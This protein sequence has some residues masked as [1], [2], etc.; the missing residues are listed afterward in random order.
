MK[1]SR[2]QLDAMLDVVIDMTKDGML[3]MAKEVYAEG[4]DAFFFPTL[5]LIS[6]GEDYMERDMVL[7]DDNFGPQ[8]EQLGKLKAE[9]G[10]M[11]VALVLGVETW[12]SAVPESWFDPNT[13]VKPVDDPNH[14]EAF[15]ITHLTYD[16]RKQLKKIA[17]KR[18][19]QGNPSLG[20]ALVV[21]NV[22]YDSLGRF[23]HGYAKGIIERGKG[24]AK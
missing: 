16:K 7:L 3:S 20:D 23:F 1:H 10:V 22:T 18:D 9:L 6:V 5:I 15:I 17:I 11:V 14:T 19:E 13:F 2:D 4:G 12:V 8:L 24:G 21:P